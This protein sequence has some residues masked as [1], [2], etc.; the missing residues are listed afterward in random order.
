LLFFVFA[1]FESVFFSDCFIDVFVVEMDVDFGS[2]TS[3]DPAGENTDT[4]I[5]E[6]KI[7]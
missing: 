4:V 7:T 5:T 3:G 2:V 6:S 1:I